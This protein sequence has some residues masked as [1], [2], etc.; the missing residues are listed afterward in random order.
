MSSMHKKSTASWLYVA[1]LVSIGYVIT[2]G[3]AQQVAHPVAIPSYT[4]SE[5]RIPEH[6]G[7]AWSDS[8]LYDK[9]ESLPGH[10][11]TALHMHMKGYL[12]TL[13]EDLVL[14]SSDKNICIARFSLLIRKSRKE[15]FETSS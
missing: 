7:W 14:E 13:Y 5:H 3:C 11:F 1:I 10:D 8:L 6:E 12:S 2:S 4:S 9:T 15:S